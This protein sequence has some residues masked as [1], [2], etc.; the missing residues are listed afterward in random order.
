MSAPEVRAVEMAKVL[1]TG[2]R[3]TVAAPA[4]QGDEWG[5]LQL[6]RAARP[7]LVREVARHDVVVVPRLAPYLLPVAL[8][9][10]TVVV[11]DLYNPAEEEAQDLLGDP[12]ADAWLQVALASK[13]LQ[14][15]F[16]D[17]VLCAT[18]SQRERLMAD[19]DELGLGTSAR[20]TLRVVPFGIGPP[21][22]KSGRR[23]LR[24]RFPA[25]GSDDTLILWW[26]GIWRWFD[27]ETAIRAFARLATEEPKAKLLFTAGRHPRAEADQ[28]TGTDAA[29][30]L[31]ASLG[32][33]DKRVFF[34]EEWVP[35]HERGH[36]LLDADVGLTLHRETPEAK[37][38]A[39]ARYMDYLWAG[40]PCVLASGDEL[41]DTFADAG[42]A[43]PVRPEDVEGTHA[44]LKR[45]V[46][47]PSLR[48]RSRSRS[49]RLA[50][51]FRWPN[52][53]APLLSALGDLDGP[54]PG[55]PGARALAQA[56]GS[57]YAKRIRHRAL[58]RR[59]NLQRRS[60]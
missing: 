44:A 53:V 6:V 33:L 29:R 59:A 7:R 25:I 34:L 22:P 19:F 32:L 54:R 52:A 58:A 30:S 50:E 57:Y 10:R 2:Y 47:E 8:A 38:A 49:E 36:Y 56:M 51:R 40:L 18:E 48:E 60:R 35:H 27:P 5:G 41:S 39:R 37:V 12:A 20:P 17:I 1:Q 9:R 23:P 13:R 55:K 43:L 14:L 16:A 45:M 31:A 11:A 21:P 24:E 42:F 46:R 15:R 3:A 28:V 26:G 4:W